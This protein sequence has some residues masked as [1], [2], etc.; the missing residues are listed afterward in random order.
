MINKNIRIIFEGL[1]F[2][3]ILQLAVGPVCLL[4]FNTSATN[5]F[6]NAMQVVLAVSI[7][8]LLF[9]IL[10]LL[11]SSFA[12]NKKEVRYLLNLLNGLILIFFGLNL[13]LSVFGISLING[14]PYF[15]NLLGHNYFLTGITLTLSNPLTI[16]F[17][18][19]VFSKKVSDNDYTRTNLL[20]FAMGCVLATFLFLSM[21][22]ILGIYFNHFLPDNI[23]SILNIIVGLLI[24]FWGIKL[25]IN[26]NFKASS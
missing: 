9:I 8:D 15:K 4:V 19:S 26:K 17:W 25:I 11:S 23:V 3:M 6:F 12:L 16:I 2:G 21:I 20:F 7:I 18:S 13:F 22:S 10:S 1:Y 5:G 24:I 14:L